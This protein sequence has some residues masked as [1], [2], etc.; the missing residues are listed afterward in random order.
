MENLI[1]LGKYPQN[2]VALIAREFLRVVYLETLRDYADEMQ[3]TPGDDNIRKNMED[4][5]KAQETMIIFL[6]G[7]E[8]FLQFVHKDAAEQQKDDDEFDRF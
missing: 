4:I 6:D 2:D 3:K 1:D 8:E 7:N 5:L